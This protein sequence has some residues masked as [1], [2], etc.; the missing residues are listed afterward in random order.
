MG[1]N[2]TFMEDPGDESPREAKRRI[3]HY[4]QGSYAG[5]I[6]DWAKLAVSVAAATVT[7]M[8]WATS[9]FIS[10][11]E[12]AQHLDQQAKDF[13]R[14]S[15]TQD[16]YA[17]AERVTASQLSEINARLTRIET[18]LDARAANGNGVRK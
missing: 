13:S 4:H 10:R 12:M 11:A 9:N 2:E 17:D 15:M 3:R 18:M 8:L 16:H 7:V 14:V 1:D 6:P 5:G